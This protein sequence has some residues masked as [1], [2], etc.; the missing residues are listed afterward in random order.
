[1]KAKFTACATG[2]PEPEVEWFKNGEKIY[3]SDRIII[4]TENHG[5]L[6]MTMS[7]VTEADVGRYAC[8][9]TNIHGQDTC[10]AELF[11]ECK[12][13]FYYSIIICDFYLFV[14]YST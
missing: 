5:L 6:R 14:I 12:L 7:D 3:A 2:Y 1:M 8:K 13:L 9:I 10:F 4:E 11:Y